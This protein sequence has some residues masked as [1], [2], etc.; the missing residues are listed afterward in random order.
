LRK[1]KTKS[2]RHFNKNHINF[3]KRDNRKN[4]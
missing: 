3:S 2:F 1:I 4:Y